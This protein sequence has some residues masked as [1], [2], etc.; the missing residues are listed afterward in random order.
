MTV[1]GLE[2]VEK[3]TFVFVFLGKDDF[4][5]RMLYHLKFKFTGI[6]KH[7]VCYSGERGISSSYSNYE[8]PRSSE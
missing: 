6:K 5:L 7:T 8:I 1:W 2:R 3:A 4:L